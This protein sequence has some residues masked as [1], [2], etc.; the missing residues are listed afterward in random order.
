MTRHVGAAFRRPWLVIATVTLFVVMLTVTPHAPLRHRV[1]TS[2]AVWSADGE[3]LRLTRAAD[4]Q[5]RMWTPLDDIS[6]VLI[7]AFVTKEDR[8]FYW[9]PGVNPA[10]LARAAYRTYRGHRREGGSTLTM[11]L[12]RMLDKRTTGRPSCKL[13]QTLAEIWI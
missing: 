6:P 7:D 4:D 3:L 13:R 12:V 5:Y 8:W 1:P 11:Q 10:S 9:H 2:T